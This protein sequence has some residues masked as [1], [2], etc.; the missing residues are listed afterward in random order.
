[1][2]F[3]CALGGE[4]T[5]QAREGEEGPGRYLG[6]AQETSV[7]PSPGKAPGVR[8]RAEGDVCEPVST[9]L[10]LWVLVTGRG[11]SAPHHHPLS[12]SR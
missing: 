9:Q 12:T 11:F 5:Q 10:L 6:A 3:Q 7:N 1:M 8:A 4:D 2:L